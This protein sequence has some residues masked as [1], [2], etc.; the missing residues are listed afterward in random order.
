V[1]DSAVDAGAGEG[2]AQLAAIAGYED[3]TRHLADGSTP[4][5]E[6][7]SDSVRLVERTGIQY[8]DQ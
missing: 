8:D 7:P 4:C 5:S 2:P 3:G 6:L 1:I